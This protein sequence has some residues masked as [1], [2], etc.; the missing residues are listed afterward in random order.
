MSEKKY[1]IIDAI[2]MFRMRYCIELPEEMPEGYSPLTWGS[3]S[4]VCG[5]VKEFSQEH[6]DEVVSSHRVV[7]LEEALQQHREDNPW[8][9]AWSDEV[10]IKNAITPID[11]DPKKDPSHPEYSGWKAE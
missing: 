7:T 4:V 6:L 3:D 8:C 5:E 2:S 1:V 11:Y 10:R 9:D